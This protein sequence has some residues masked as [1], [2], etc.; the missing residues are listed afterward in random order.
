MKSIIITG[1]IN[2]GKST[3]L[4]E[5]VKTINIHFGGFICLPKYH[6]KKKLFLVKLL[7]DNTT[8][9]LNTLNN[10]ENVIKIGNF[11]INTNAIKCMNKCIF[12]DTNVFNHLIIDEFGLLELQKKGIF[13]GIEYALLSNVN[14]IIIIRDFI[15]KN[16]LNILK[17]YRD[18]WDIIH[19]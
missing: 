19:I 15:L 7:R 14:I 3:T 10:S 17:Y 6:N 2:S 11:F 9:P 1:K 4:F 5:A 18:N 12:E 13:P 8:F 16:A